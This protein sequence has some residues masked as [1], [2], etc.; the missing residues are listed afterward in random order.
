MGTTVVEYDA[1]CP[2]CTNEIGHVSWGQFTVLP[3]LGIAPHPGEDLEDSDAK[4]LNPHT[5]ASPVLRK[6]KSFASNATPPK[7]EPEE[8]N[9][10]CAPH[11][12]PALPKAQ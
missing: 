6:H 12:V 7:E 10:S 8:K 3:E 9:R 4:P 5:G 2:R 11:C 1:R